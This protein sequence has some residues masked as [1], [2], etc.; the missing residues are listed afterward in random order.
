MQLAERNEHRER[1]ENQASEQ[2]EDE[3]HEPRKA[4][5]SQHHN[6]SDISRH[7]QAQTGAAEV[8]R[9]DVTRSA[10]SSTART[11]N[12]SK[13]ETSG[14]AAVKA[15]KKQNSGVTA[16][17]RWQRKQSARDTV[18][19]TMSSRA[20]AGISKRRV[21]AIKADVGIQQRKQEQR[22]RDAGR[23]GQR[24][25]VGASQRR[26]TDTYPDAP[27]NDTCPLKAETGTV[28]ETYG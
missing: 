22:N 26:Q 3:S 4:V 7:R 27:R 18:G 13:S 15:G 12:S 1:A 9:V 2:I 24:E 28:K 6:V 11:N 5:E 25:M 16:T 10:A 8:G 23:R 14:R 17:K 21:A 19:E 20:R